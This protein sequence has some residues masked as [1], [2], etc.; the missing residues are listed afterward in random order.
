MREQ[1]PDSWSMR[2][3]ILD[4]SKRANVGHIGS[5]LCVVEILS[6]LYTQVLRITSPLDPDRDRF[7]LSKGHAGLALYAALVERGWVKAAALGAFCGDDSVFGVHPEA[8]VPGI[9][10]STGSLGHGLSIA[11]GAALAARLQGSKR[12]AFCLIS[13]AECNEGSIW[14]AAMF[15]SHHRL[16][17]LTAIVDWN[18]QQ[19]LGRTQ[20]VLDSS[21]LPQR[22]EAFGWRV[23]EVNGH[24]V[25]DLATAMN[26]CGP[27]SSSPHVILARTVF[28]K[29]VSFMEDGV[30]LTQTHLPVQPVNW[31]YL[32]MSDLE[33]QTALRELDS[34]R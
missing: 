19:A 2:R 22:W 18:G 33:Y 11:A 28:G 26:G 30:P 27:T 12:R 29:G 32:P 7:I 15:A 6:A 25:S 23:T 9:D 31:H 4:E 8:V 10:F 5:C 17:N 34:L 21:N 1:G 14:E 13:D 24:S 3:T 20:D 16:E